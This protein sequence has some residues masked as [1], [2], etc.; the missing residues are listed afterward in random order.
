MGKAARRKQGAEARD[1][2][3]ERS[4]RRFANRVM[5]GQA[6]RAYDNWRY[7]ETKDSAGNPV[8]VDRVA[9][10]RKR[11]TVGFRVPETVHKEQ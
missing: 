8:I 7:V 3:Q 11:R 6:T 1:R 2:K 5:A 4:K 10:I 9:S